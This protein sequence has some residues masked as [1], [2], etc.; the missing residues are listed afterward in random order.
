MKILVLN[1]NTSTVVTKKIEA[2][3]KRVAR[4]D[5]EVVVAQIPH[6]PESLESFYD[7]ALA[8]PYSIEMVKKAN[9][10]DFDAIVLAAFCDPSIEALKEISSIPVYGIA[11]TTYAVATLLGNKFAVLTEKKPKESVKVHQ[12]R[13]FGLESRFAGVRALNM[14][15][16]EIAENP[17]KVKSTGI[18]IARQMIEKDGAEVIIMGCAS[19]AGYADDLE[20]E[21]NVPVLD[22]ISITYKVA[23]GLADL[24]IK[25]SKLGLYQVPEPKKMN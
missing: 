21:L 24:K 15:V 11:E 10:D 7:E 25:H 3:I 18:E 2:S 19:M 12:V 9:D 23:E 4:S 17:E 5:V 22:P 16:V 13:K 1:P 6:G 14:G 8:A 20:H